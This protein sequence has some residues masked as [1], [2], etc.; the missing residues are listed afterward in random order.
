MNI[1]IAPDSFKDSLSAKQVG[2]AVQKGILN[3]PGDW[4]IRIIPM[5]DGGEGTVEALVDATSGKFLD[6]EVYNPLM[7]TIL[8]RWGILGD[9]KT[10]VIEMAAASG[11]ELLSPDERNPWITSTYGTGQLIK[12]AL[13]N[14]C[15]RIIMGIG[16]SATTDAGIGMAQA[17]GVELLDKDEKPVGQGGGELSKI[18]RIDLSGIDPR[19]EN[20]K[21]IIACDVINPLI[22]KE[23]AA[24]IYAPQKGADKEMAKHLDNNLKH[25]TQV[26][27]KQLGK[28]VDNIPGAGAAGGLGA[29][30]IAFTDAILKP[31]FEIICRE[32]RLEDHMQWADLVITGEGKM[33][34]QTQFGKTPVGVSRIAKKYDK[35]VIAIAGTLGEGY[36]ELCTYGFDA[37]FSIIDKPMS[38]DEALIIAPQLLERCANS[39]IRL[40]IQGKKSFSP[41]NHYKA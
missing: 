8:A 39:I 34:Y 17:L 23:G 41:A 1:L 36:Q 5:A 26:V 24:I 10:A 18:N 25:F 6:T 37:I 30:F 21:I 2:E 12:A 15:N 16:G 19:I 28:E 27:K 40:W 9:G 14:G 20:C 35:P 11:L 31:G 4:N 38:L 7:R 29:G 33:D 3:I 32:T 13:D 22:G